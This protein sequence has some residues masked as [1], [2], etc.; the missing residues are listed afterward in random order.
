MPSL[1]WHCKVTSSTCHRGQK[2]HSWNDGVIKHQ[3]WT[4]IWTCCL[5]ESLCKPGCSSKAA[6][7]TCSWQGGS[8]TDWLEFNWSLLT[9]CVFVMDKKGADWLSDVWGLIKNYLLEVGRVVDGWLQIDAVAG[10]LAPSWKMIG[11]R[12][13]RWKARYSSIFSFFFFFTK[14]GESIYSCPILCVQCLHELLSLVCTSKYL[15]TIRGRFGT[16]VCFMSAYLESET[17]DRWRWTCASCV[18]LALT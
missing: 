5:Q 6:P 11:G 16:G 13:G 7:S 9:L 18:L 4:C 12:E 14:K 15:M 2:N 17:G 10:E 8:L 3:G 1:V